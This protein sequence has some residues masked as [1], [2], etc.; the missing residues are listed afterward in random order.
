MAKWRITGQTIPTAAEPSPRIIEQ[1]AVNKAD[2]RQIGA[3]FVESGLEFVRA[4]PDTLRGGGWRKRLEFQRNASG[5]VTVR[6]YG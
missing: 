3:M 1:Y 5:Q 6:D 2:A 4:W